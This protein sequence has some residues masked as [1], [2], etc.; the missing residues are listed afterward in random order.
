MAAI[1]S[2]SFHRAGL[3]LAFIVGAIG[4]F[5]IARDA[6]MLRLW[7][8]GADKIPLLIFNMLSG[9]AEVAFACLAAYGLV[10]AVGWIVGRLRGA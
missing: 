7:E 5:F 3:I 8:V 9:L 6:M 2:W 1:G 4:L 10:R